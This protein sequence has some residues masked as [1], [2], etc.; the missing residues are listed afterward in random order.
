MQASLPNLASWY[1]TGNNIQLN[2]DMPRRS[3]LIRIDAKVSDPW[4]RDAA[5]FRHPNIIRW[6]RDNR[7]E[8]IAQA[9]T[10]ARAWFVAGKP[11]GSTKPL[12]SFEN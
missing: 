3:C 5:G 7:G 10:L 11:S 8:I 6:V 1:A 2:G 4:N 9:M 12:G